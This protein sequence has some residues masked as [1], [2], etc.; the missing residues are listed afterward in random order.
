MSIKLVRIGGNIGNK[1]LDLFYYMFLRKYKLHC[2][3]YVLE[4]IA[5]WSIIR[6]LR[7]YHVFSRERMHNHSNATKEVFRSSSIHL[8]KLVYYLSWGKYWLLPL[9]FFSTL[10]LILAQIIKILWILMSKFPDNNIIGEK[11]GNLSYQLIAGWKNTFFAKD[12]EVLNKDGFLLKEEG[13]RDASTRNEEAISKITRASLKFSPAISVISAKDNSIKFTPSSMDKVVAI[14]FRTPYYRGDDSEGYR[15]SNPESFCFLAANLRHAGYKPVFFGSYSQEVKSRLR[16][17][18]TL[19]EDLDL[20]VYYDEVC[21]VRDCRLLIHT[22]SGPSCLPLLFGKESLVVD[23]PF[24]TGA[25]WPCEKSRF[26]LKYH[27]SSV[28][29]RY[30]SAK[31]IMSINWLYNVCS[32]DSGCEAYFRELGLS[33]KP[34]SGIHIFQSAMSMLEGREYIPIELQEDANRVCF[35]YLKKH[36]EDYY[37]S[38]STAMNPVYFRLCPSALGKPASS[39][40]SSLSTEWSP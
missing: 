17:C 5:P 38:G 2:K 39:F 10:S 36:Y 26:M 3:L 1:A 40:A 31:E 35:K 27:W 12:F 34:N 25:E 33:L 28:Y 32:G 29:Q 18:A 9:L 22:A 19:I 15:D 20:P 14:T 13:F 11:A 37:L 24:F 21:L 6:S 7:S 30:L 8:T 16:Q 23:H 4:S